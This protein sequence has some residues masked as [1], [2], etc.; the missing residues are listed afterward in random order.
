MQILLPFYSV[1][2]LG[3]VLPGL[4]ES[5]LAVDIVRPVDDLASQHHHTLGFG[6]QMVV[7][8]VFE[9]VQPSKRRA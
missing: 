7:E 5:I 8:E 4:A 1:K 3:S 9:L 2:G 6:V